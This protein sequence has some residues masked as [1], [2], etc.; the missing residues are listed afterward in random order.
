MKMLLC[1]LYWA[2]MPVLVSAGTVA[3]DWPEF[4]GPG[5]QGHAEG[6]NLPVRWSGDE[7][8]V[9]KTVVPGVGWSSPI[10]FNEVVYL[11]TALLDD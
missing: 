1:R 3:G 4:R 9:W 10:V 7:N 6:S 2:V 5:G 11:T 8:I